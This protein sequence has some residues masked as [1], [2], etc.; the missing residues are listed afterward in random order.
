MKSFR[1]VNFA[2]G[3]T[4]SPD[5]NVTVAKFEEIQVKP[6]KLVIIPKKPQ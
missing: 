6:G 5:F 1:T 4:N 2:S 3:Y